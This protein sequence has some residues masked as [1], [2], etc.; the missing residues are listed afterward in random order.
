MN[1]LIC[2]V[3]MPALLG[4]AANMD[5]NFETALGTAGLTTR[6][7]R[8]DENLLR[9]FRS[10]EFTTPLYRSFSENPWRVPFFVQT[11]RAEAATAAG[12]PSSL[13][14]LG[15]R[16][17]GVGTRRTLLGNPNQAEEDAALKPGSLKTILEAMKLAGT[18]KGPIPALTNVP[19]ET[20]RAAA[21]ILGVARRVLEMRRLAFIRMGNVG[22]LYD[23]NTSLGEDPTGSKFDTF[24]NAA[25]NAD[26]SYLFAGGHDIVRAAETARTMLGSVAPDEK[27]NFEVDT[28]WGQIILTGGTNDSHPERPTLLLI[29]TGGDD[30][31]INAPSNA[32]PGNWVSVLIDSAGQDKYLSDAALKDTAVA[33]FSQRKGNGKPGPGGALFGYAVLIDVAGN[34]LYRSHR[35]ALASGRFGVA[36]IQDNA[37]DDTYDGYADSQGY[38]SFGIG[39]L[40]DVSGKDSYMG[41]SQVQGVGQTMGFG[42]LAD[43]AGDD[44]YLANDSV[45]DFPSAQSAQHNTTMGQGAGN[46]RRADYSDGH[47][48]AG[49]VGILFDEK[50]NDEY[51]CGVFG[52]GVG[53]WEGVGMLWDSDGYDSYM[54][55]WY[56]QGASA[57]FAIGYLEDLAGDDKYSAG[58]NMAQGAGHDFSVGY[59]VDGAGKD[60]YKAPNLSLGAGN[61]NGVGVFVDMGGDDSY[62]SSGLTLGSGAEAT[63]GSLRSKALCLGVFLDL[64]GTDTY[65]ALATWAKNGSRTV[66]WMDKGFRI[67]ESQLGVFWDR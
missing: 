19:S 48:L 46:G 1:N 23:A 14:M 57:H 10:G 33:R 5:E 15:G 67:E 26:L 64:G 59:L 58:M 38:G 31:Y 50:G 56:V 24:L 7:A 34:D 12:T 2:A 66:N 17:L 65:P 18:F 35:P 63:K 40:E 37:G 36:V 28:P 29:D 25:R 30:T 47:S 6:S 53:Y 44:K 8:F 3:M 54:G 52:Q 62:E 16:T 20:Q 21:L 60:A 45:I 13:V 9:F 61:A 11:L 42:M 27:Y 22:G 51:S 32:N 4:Q 43:R 49:G 55:Q 41:F 39:I